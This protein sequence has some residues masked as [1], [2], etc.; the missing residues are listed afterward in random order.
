MDLSWL[1]CPIILIDWTDFPAGD[2]VS[3]AARRAFDTS[4]VP[5]TQPGN[6]TQRLF[7]KLMQYAIE[8]TRTR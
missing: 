8:L 1:T 5:R 6:L 2:W 3:A 7:A 4:F